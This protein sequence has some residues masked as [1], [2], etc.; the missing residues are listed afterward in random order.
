MLHFIN[1]KHAYNNL[2]SVQNMLYVTFFEYATYKQL[3]IYFFNFK[4]A[5]LEIK[6]NKIVKFEYSF[7]LKISPCISSHMHAEYQDQTWIC[8]ET[9]P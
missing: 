4:K 6:N 9:V 5:G 3:Q 2:C 7:S 1:T 8:T